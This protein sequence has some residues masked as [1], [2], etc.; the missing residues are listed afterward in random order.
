MKKK[1]VAMAKKQTSAKM[2]RDGS[3]E[4]FGIWGMLASVTSNRNIESIGSS[5]FI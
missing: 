1:R 5:Y 4:R 2:A 3:R